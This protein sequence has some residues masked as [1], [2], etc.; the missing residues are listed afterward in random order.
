MAGANGNDLSKKEATIGSGPFKLAE[1]KRGSYIHLV[2]NPDYFKPGL[3]YLDEIYLRVIPD[4][5]SRAV[6]F[7][8]GT[9]DVLRGGDIENFEVRRLQTDC[10][11]KKEKLRRSFAN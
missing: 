6:A 7:E 1:W 11:E 4:A 3:P 9:V 5:A 8:R 2:K 10:E